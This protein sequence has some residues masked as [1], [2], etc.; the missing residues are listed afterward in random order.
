MIISDENYKPIYIESIDTPTTTE[1]FWTLNL[2]ELDFMLQKLEMFEELT[3]PTLSLKIGDY[4]VIAPT[5]WNLLVYSRE[6]SQL[7]VVEISDL[8]RGGFQALSFEFDRDDVQGD[9]V[10]VIDYEQSNLVRTPLLNKNIMLCHHLGPN[11][12]VCLAP[13]DNYNKFLKDKVIGDLME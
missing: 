2:D 13:T 11:H 10:V 1:Y 6:T 3:T 8:T 7:D 9:E 5:N 4:V 12:W